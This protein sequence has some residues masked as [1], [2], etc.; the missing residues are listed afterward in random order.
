M[1]DPKQVKKPRLRHANTQ[2]KFISS[3]NVPVSPMEVISEKQESVYNNK[4]AALPPA[5]DRN[6]KRMRYLNSRQNTLKLQQVGANLGQPGPS[7]GLS[8]GF[9]M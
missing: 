4:G 9:Q 1:S 7:S 5:Y 6:E 2:K 8:T 3:S